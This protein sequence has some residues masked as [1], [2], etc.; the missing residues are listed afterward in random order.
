MIICRKEAQGAQE[1]E[2]AG[3]LLVDVLASLAP[4]CG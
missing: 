3:Q 4:S 1:Q 2:P